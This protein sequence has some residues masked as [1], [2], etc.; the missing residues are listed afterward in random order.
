[1]NITTASPFAIPNEA[2]AAAR[3]ALRLMQRLSHGTLTVHLP[4]GTLL[5]FGNGD[6][7]S[8]AITLRNW[9]VCSARW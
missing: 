6:L 2:P 7:P 3:T 8:A 4:G 9:N 1:M 5:R